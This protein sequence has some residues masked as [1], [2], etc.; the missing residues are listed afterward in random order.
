MKLC[1]KQV[2]LD[3]KQE[4]GK[5]TAERLRLCQ[6]KKQEYLSRSQEHD[7]DTRDNY[8]DKL[9]LWIQANTPDNRS[10]VEL[11]NEMLMELYEEELMEIKTRVRQ[12]KTANYPR[13]EMS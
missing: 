4:S 11:K 13:I 10:L 2:Y 3:R 12:Y 9:S 8:T 1:W 7:E 5:D 6:K